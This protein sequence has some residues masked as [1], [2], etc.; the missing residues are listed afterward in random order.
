MLLDVAFAAS[1]APEEG[2]FAT[3]GLAFLPPESELRSFRRFRFRDSLELSKQ[4]VVNL[5][6]AI[7]ATTTSLAVW[8]LPDG[9]PRIWGLVISGSAPM[10]APPV[11]THPSFLHAPFLVVRAP[12]PGVLYVY[13]RRELQLLYVRGTA[14]FRPP[15]GL[16]QGILRDRAGL[17][18]LE[19][20]ALSEIATRISLL[21]HG[22]T[23]L[24]TP[25]EGAIPAGLL[26]V[27]YRFDP[28]SAM[29]RDA[30]R[31]PVSN[32]DRPG[33]RHAFDFLAQL[34]QVDG[35]V[36]L[37]SDLEIQGFGAKIRSSG[38]QFPLIAED[39]DGDRTHELPLSAIPGTRHRSAA[40]FCA[41]Q[42]GRAFAIVISQDGDVSLFGRHLDDSVRRIGP[43]AF[44]A[45]LAAGE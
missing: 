17:E 39:A 36:H 34:S 42:P 40:M 20:N 29:L 28:P 4:E 3:F 9:P 13:H 31:E 11:H 6:A 15:S 16:L 33:E 5:A 1:M 41:Q 24:I 22:G 45:G 2:R 18:P 25:P 12:A 26:D 23:M 19:A 27:S 35:A 8:R 44:G 37:T 32:L 10:G 14:H 30:I 38:D 21:G 7:D 43:F